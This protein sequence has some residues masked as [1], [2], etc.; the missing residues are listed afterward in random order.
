[1][2]TSLNGYKIEVT[3]FVRFGSTQTIEQQNFCHR[4]VKL[5]Y[6]KLRQG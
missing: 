4:I 2:A 3:T 5:R 1:M 6:L